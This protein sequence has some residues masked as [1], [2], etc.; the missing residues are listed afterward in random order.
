MAICV[1][2]AIQVHAQLQKGASYYGGT[3]G[4]NGTSTKS[5]VVNNNETSQVKGYS[6]SPEAQYGYF[7]NGTTVVGVGIKYNVT[8]TK[9]TY[10]RPDQGSSGVS[11]SVY[12]LPFVRK[13]KAL[14]NHWSV[15]LHA[16]IG[17]GYYW[18]RTKVN[19]SNGDTKY[20]Y[21]QHALSVKPGVAYHFPRSGWAVE[22]YADIL[23]LNAQYVSLADQHVRSFR[24]SSGLTTSVPSYLTIRIAKYISTASK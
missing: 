24:F 12:L 9:T 5:S 18:D 16:E 6:I 2:L 20:D 14:N 4:F 11:Q 17:S 22:A 21:W 3:I 15:F 8:S 13:Y 1:C 23:S 7:L 10:D 19:A